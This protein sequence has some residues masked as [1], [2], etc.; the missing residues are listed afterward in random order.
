MNSKTDLRR[1]AKELRKTLPI[2]E[3]SDKLAD[4]IRSST[5]YTKLICVNYLKITKISIFH[6]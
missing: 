5:N 2:S 1:R 3:I 4:L 6:A